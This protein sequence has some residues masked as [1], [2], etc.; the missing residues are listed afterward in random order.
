LLLVVTQLN[1]KAVTIKT[2]NQSFILAVLA[3]IM[4]ACG[5]L[6]SRY[7]EMHGRV[8]HEIHDKPLSNTVV[9]AL[10][11]GKEKNN[12][13][14]K[15]ICYHV[16]STK[17][18]DKGFFSIPEWREPSSFSQ[19]KDKSIH[20]FAFRRY[21]RTSELTSQI[22]TPKNYIYYLAK[23]RHIENENKAREAR[24]R[25]LQLLVGKTTCDLKGESRSNLRPLFIEVI[26]EAELIAVSDK[27]RQVVEKLK[28]WL[29]YVSSEEDN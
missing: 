13:S 27:D 1:I 23:P 25:Y 10:W 4:S 29:T 17:S 9:V 19:L 24:L 28:G 16:E 21:Y 11:K 7:S 8:I 26:E 5:L 6:G 3:L 12:D 18:D 2:L 15:E 20:V 14:E 22:I